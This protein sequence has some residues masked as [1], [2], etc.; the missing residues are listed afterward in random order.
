MDAF[1]DGRM[2]IQDQT[3][4]AA[5]AARLS[6]RRRDLRL[7]LAE[8]ASRCGVSL[9]QVHRYEIG[10]NVISATMLWRLARCLDVPVAWFF[11][12][13]ETEDETAG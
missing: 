4:T 5:V 3:V 11:D 10:A 9:Q 12:D 7:S 13:L 8:V 1:G 6:Q 2:E